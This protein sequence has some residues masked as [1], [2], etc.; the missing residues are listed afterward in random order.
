MRNRK[1][2]SRVAISLGIMMSLGVAVLG[3][4]SISRGGDAP[5]PK[6]TSTPT[7]RSSG[8]HEESYHSPIALA[9]SAD[10]TR[11]LV[12]N[13]GTGTVTLVDPKSARV[14]HEI[15]TGEKPAGVALSRDGRR[16]V[17]THWY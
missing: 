6:L 1:L 7:A 9:V 4:W 3:P 5:G 11:L 12:A 16:G 14:L 13:Q 15:K 17:V 2:M 10:G 8:S